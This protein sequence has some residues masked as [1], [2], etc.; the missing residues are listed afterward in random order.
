[1]AL[2]NYTTSIAAEKTIGEV[3]A[4]LVRHQCR[5]MQTRYSPT[6]EIVSLSFTLATE[7]GERDYSLPV[8]VDGVVQTLI[9]EKEAGRLPNLPWRV[10]QDAKLL[11]AQASRVAWRILKDWL[12]AQL[13]IIQS[14]TVTLEQV[15]LPFMLVEN[16]ATVFDVYRAQN[17]LPAPRGT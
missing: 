15:M 14:R 11:R 10:A 6:G 7:F 16:G 12:E 4:L 1:M 9:H 8:N 17:A 2:L 3:Q 5:G 13:A